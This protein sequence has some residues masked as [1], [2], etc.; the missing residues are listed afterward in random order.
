MT[1]TIEL[2][3]NKEAALRAKAQEQGVS[4]EQYVQQYSTGIW[5][6]SQPFQTPLASLSD[7]RLRVKCKACRS[8]GDDSHMVKISPWAILCAVLLAPLCFS[9]G[10]FVQNTNGTEILR[11]VVMEDF[12]V[13]ES[14]GQSLY[15]FR[16]YKD[17]SHIDAIKDISRQIDEWLE[18][19]R[20]P[21]FSQL[22]A[23]QIQ[24]NNAGIIL[25]FATYWAGKHLDATQALIL[26]DHA[27]L[28]LSAKAVSEF[29]GYL[30]R[31]QKQDPA[32][33]AEYDQAKP[34]LDLPPR[35]DA[36]F[37]QFIATRA[38]PSDFHIYDAS[39]LIIRYRQNEVAVESAM[40][41]QR[42]TVQGIA[43][44]IAEDI[45]DQPYVVVG[46][47]MWGIRAGFAKS[48]EP[49]LVALHRGMSV[50]VTGTV[51]GFLL[52]SMQLE[53]CKLLPPADIQAASQGR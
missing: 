7:K 30:A 9:Q 18:H 4:A 28:N 35:D 15:G 34:F 39:Q 50:V 5:S 33:I 52:G 37:V 12:R 41:G 19:G 36:G 44:D 38:P 22:P 27:R 53:D 45:F 13:H 49:D 3:D 21:A 16:Q 48:S 32:F 8:R 47:Q 10:R 24:Q 40:R 6:G 42:I 31:A 29:S 20:R 51:S 25:L 17:I 43:T 14:G 23:L 11:A 1:L 2:P 46:A 26:D